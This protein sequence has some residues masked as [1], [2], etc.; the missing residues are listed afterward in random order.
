MIEKLSRLFSFI[1]S[2][3]KGRTTYLKYLS[4]FDADSDMFSC[5]PSPN[6]G[7]HELPETV[8]EFWRQVEDEN[9]AMFNDN[10]W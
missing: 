3:E 9:V 4:L 2:M 10:K 8:R 1:Y 6:C 5:I 7:W